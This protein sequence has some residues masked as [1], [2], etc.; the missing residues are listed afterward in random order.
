M[1]VDSNF[2]HEYIVRPFFSF[3]PSLSLTP[4]F[5]AEEARIS[6]Y[7]FLA[8]VLREGAQKSST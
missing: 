5:F 3:L 4:V 6:C 2:S 8:L 1:S 7:T